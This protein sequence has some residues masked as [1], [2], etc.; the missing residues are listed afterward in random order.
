[1]HLTR[2]S[3]TWATCGVVAAAALASAGPTSAASNS[4]VVHGPVPATIHLDSAAATL[5]KDGSDGIAIVKSGATVLRLRL[6]ANVDTSDT[7]LSPRRRRQFARNG[8]TER[9]FELHLGS[10]HRPATARP[11]GRSAA[12]ATA[13]DAHVYA[14]S[15]AGGAC[16]VS[17]AVRSVDPSLPRLVR[18]LSGWF[19]SSS[20]NPTRPPHLHSDA[21]A[22]AL[23]AAAVRRGAKEKVISYRAHERICV[24]RPH[25]PCRYAPLDIRG[26]ADYIGQFWSV[27]LSGIG[28]VGTPDGDYTRQPGKKCW[29]RGPHKRISP[30]TGFLVPQHLSEW[31]LSF[32]PAAARANGTTVV[33]F[34]S[35][36]DAGSFVIDS[37]GRA[38]SLSSRSVRIR[39]PGFKFTAT[40]TYTYPASIPHDAPSPVCA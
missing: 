7:Y 20:G 33:R 34:R 4:V 10:R 36:W 8:A 25:E 27:D 38:S 30:G 31:R 17:G 22:G 3:R 1:M 6:C 13:G 9:A 40:I 35:F 28:A 2:M 32:A 29:E 14:V 18:H 12:I 37:Q 16:L 23:I 5:E 19:G 24:P 26:A 11:L 15:L 21:K 39:T